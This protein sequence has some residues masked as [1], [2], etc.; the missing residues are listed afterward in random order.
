MLCTSPSLIFSVRYPNKEE[1]ELDD[2]C[3]TEVE[4]YRTNDMTDALN[5]IQANLATEQINCFDVEMDEDNFDKRY[6]VL[7]YN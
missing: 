2:D 6:D 5:E 3:L 4:Q 7:Q 1:E